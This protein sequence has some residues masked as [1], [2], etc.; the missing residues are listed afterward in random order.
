MVAFR[1]VADAASSFCIAA[2]S[3]PIASTTD[4]LTLRQIL[5]A[6]G[7]EPGTDE[8]RRESHSSMRHFNRTRLAVRCPIKIEL[9]PERLPRPATD[10]VHK[11]MLAL[12]GVCVFR[13]P[14]R[15]HNLVDCQARLTFRLVPGID[16]RWHACQ[17]ASCCKVTVCVR[18]VIANAPLGMIVARRRRGTSVAVL[19]RSV[20][21]IDWNA[22]ELSRGCSA[23]LLFRQNASPTQDLVSRSQRVPRP[24]RR[25]FL[26]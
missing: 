23:L 14:E 20:R 24:R 19:R 17:P 16:G 12:L 9:A 4:V 5:I 25:P 11:T 26:Q 22:V 2:A 21:G 13:P 6:D 15:S 18:S 1:L 10:L 8:S 7:A 3:N